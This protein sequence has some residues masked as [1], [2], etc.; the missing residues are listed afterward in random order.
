MC[1]L[2]LFL[3]PSDHSVVTEK[4]KR[5]NVLIYCPLHCSLFLIFPSHPIY[6][7][8]QL[9]PTD[10]DFYIMELDNGLFV[11]GK[12]RG[13]NSRF[14]NHSCDPNCEL[15]RWVVKGSPRIGK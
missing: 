14:I 1:G 9:T 4:N 11:D 6:F 13:S 10:R 8:L 5:R 3:F 15:Q 12:Y 7:F 2:V